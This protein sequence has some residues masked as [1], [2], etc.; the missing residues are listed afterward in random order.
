L[1]DDGIEAAIFNFMMF[2]NLRET[3]CEASA[4]D[5]NINRLHLISEENFIGTLMN[6][7]VINYPKV[8]AT[9]LSKKQS[10]RE[11]ILNIRIGN[12]K[13]IRISVGKTVEVNEV[14]L[15]DPFDLRLS[16]KE[17]HEFLFSDFL[18][19][20]PEKQNK[21]DLINSWFPLS[22]PVTLHSIDSI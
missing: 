9:L 19:F 4:D 8:I 3:F 16:E 20:H 11:G 5:E 15:N 7:K 22:L 10:L 14:P 17:A 18:L 1:K 2:T 21:N 6:F 12:Q 13:A